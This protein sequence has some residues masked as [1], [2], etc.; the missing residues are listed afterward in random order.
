[1][2]SKYTNKYYSFPE[3]EIIKPLLKGAEIKRYLTPIPNY[4]LIFPYRI[5]YSD[6]E[7]ISQKEMEICHSE[8]WSYLNE[9]KEKLEGRENG[10]MKIGNWYGYVYLKNMTEFSK[11]KILTQVLCKESSLSLDLDNKFH[12]V[13]GGTAGGYGIEINDSINPYSMIS[14]LNSKLIQ[15]YIQQFASP[16]Q[17]G[18]YAYNKSTLGVVPIP[19]CNSITFDFKSFVEIL[20]S[21]NNELQELTQKFQRAI[22]RKFEIDDLP[23]K[24]QNWHIL[25]FKEFITE[26]GKKKVKL[27]LSQEAEWEDY[28]LQESQ[29]ALSLKA[30]IKTTDNEI[31]RMVYAL[32]ELTEEEI[33]IVEGA[34]EKTKI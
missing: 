19:F 16:F 8:I 24:L 28:F 18:F 6:F 31:D 26:L 33:R 22:Q 2:Y 29:K 20:T 14:I 10:K 17:G 21:L 30:K 13:G 5:T 7:I 4:K 1:M 27:N 25:T 11:P 12:F 34:N 3:S 32:Y 9:C 15:W 23:N